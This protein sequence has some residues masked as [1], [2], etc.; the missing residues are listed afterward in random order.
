MSAKGGLMGTKKVGALPS[1][2]EE[3]FF[4]PYF[5][6]KSSNGVRFTRGNLIVMMGNNKK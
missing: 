5:D 2:E 1:G 3:A 6:I 4:L